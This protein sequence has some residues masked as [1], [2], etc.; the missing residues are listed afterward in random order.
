MQLVGFDFYI[1]FPNLSIMNLWLSSSLHFY[2][3]KYLTSLLLLP[4][5][6]HISSAHYFINKLSKK[7]ASLE[8]FYKIASKQFININGF[9][10]S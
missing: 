7:K 10:V 8:S 1:N 3:V 5:V 9:S 2:E 4:V 6:R